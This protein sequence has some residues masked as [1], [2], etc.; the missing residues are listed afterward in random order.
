[1]AAQVSYFR[2]FSMETGFVL[3]KICFSLGISLLGPLQMRRD[4]F[5]ASVAVNP[6]A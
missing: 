2:D 5:S 6:F 3:S 1:M 4:G